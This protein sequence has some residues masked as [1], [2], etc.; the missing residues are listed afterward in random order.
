MRA[1]LTVVVSAGNFGINPTTGQPGYAGIASPGNAPSAFSVGARA[2]FNT[3]RA[4]TT[5][6]RLQLARSVLV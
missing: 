1:G 5:A 2:T 4:P 3:G 6:S